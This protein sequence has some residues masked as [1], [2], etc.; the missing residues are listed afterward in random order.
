LHCRR[1]VICFTH[2]R[3]F[4]F[5]SEPD[6]ILPVSKRLDFADSPLEEDGFEPSVP[7]RRQRL[8]AATPGK[9]CRFGLEPVSGSAFRAAVSDWQRREE[10]AQERDRW[11]ESVFLQR[12]VRCEPISPA[13]GAEWQK[14]TSWPQVFPSRNVAHRLGKPLPDRAGAVRRGQ[15]PLAH[16]SE[17]LAAPL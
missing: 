17:D 14:K 9:H 10:P 15:S 5:S 13:G 6:D 4:R 2:I 1:S 7:P 11:F 12:R 16:V 8:W 3:I